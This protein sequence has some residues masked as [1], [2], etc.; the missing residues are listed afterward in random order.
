MAVFQ[1][2]KKSFPDYRRYRIKTIEGP[3]D[4]GMIFEV[5]SRRYRRALEDGIFPELIVVDGGKGQLNAALRVQRDL[6]ID[7]PDIIALAK[8]KRL[9]T[10]RV[11]RDRVFLPGRKNPVLFRRGSPVLHLPDA[12]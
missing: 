7:Y 2:G 3:D 5:L 1:E 12:D 8:E 9:K 11:V 10:G 6:G 4:Y